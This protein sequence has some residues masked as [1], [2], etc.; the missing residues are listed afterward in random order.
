FGRGRGLWYRS[1]CRPRSTRTSSSSTNSSNSSNSSNSNHINNVN[2]NNNNNNWHRNISRSTGE[3]ISSNSSGSNNNTNNNTNNNDNNSNKGE[4]NDQD[5]E[6]CR[7]LFG[8]P[9]DAAP[10]QLKQRY[11]ELAKQMHPDSAQTADNASSAEAFQQLQKCYQLL[12]QKPK[13]VPE[14]LR[15]MREDYATSK[16]PFP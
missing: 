16:D 1:A 7:A 3:S 8:L 11:L 13:P 12:A 5:H 10:A 2:N 14:W 15:Q 6:R 9:A 4:S